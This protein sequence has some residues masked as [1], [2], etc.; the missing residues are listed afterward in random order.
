[1]LHTISDATL[2]K[3]KITMQKPYFFV[4]AFQFILFKQK[5]LKTKLLGSGDQA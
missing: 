1:M 2:I 3:P 5:K 4:H